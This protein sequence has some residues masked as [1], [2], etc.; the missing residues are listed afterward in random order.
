MTRKNEKI[1]D[2]V[3]EF[4][5]CD[6]V[7]DPTIVRAEDVAAFDQAIALG[8]EKLAQRAFQKARKEAA[9]YKPPNVASL[10]LERAKREVKLGQSDQGRITMAARFGDGT[11]DDD[12]EAVLAD[13]AEL[14]DDE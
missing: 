1:L 10:D 12:M 8:K 9:A 13:L 3:L 7:A 14:A 5:L 4:V 2:P 6:E 11:M